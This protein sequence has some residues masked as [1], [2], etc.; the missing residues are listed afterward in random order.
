MA[1]NL[2][3]EARHWGS[4]DNVVFV[5]TQYEGEAEDKVILQ[6]SNMNSWQRLQFKLNL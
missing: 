6:A 4:A 3:I 1:R 2:E 5:L